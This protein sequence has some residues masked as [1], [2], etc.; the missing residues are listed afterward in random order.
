MIQFCIS[1]DIVVTVAWGRIYLLLNKKWRRLLDAVLTVRDVDASTC[2]PR[3]DAPDLFFAG[4]EI[5]CESL[6]CLGVE[7]LL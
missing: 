7:L 3:G 4:V 1:I 6:D 2:F 5:R